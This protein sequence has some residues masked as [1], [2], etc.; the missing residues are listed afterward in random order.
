LIGG[1]M[2]FQRYNDG[3]NGIP[4]NRT[5]VY[6]LFWTNADFDECIAASDQSRTQNLYRLWWFMP[7]GMKIW[8]SVFREESDYTFDGYINGGDYIEVGLKNIG[9]W[10]GCS[11]S[12]YHIY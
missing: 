8:N 11:D 4:S 3:Y 12:K 6:S 10:N 9:R 2:K 1:K 7:D 5:T